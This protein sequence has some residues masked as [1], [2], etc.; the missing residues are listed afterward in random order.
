MLI[1]PPLTKRMFNINVS[2]FSYMQWPFAK[3]EVDFKV[4]TSMKFSLCTHS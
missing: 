1:Y 4:L 2:V 3:T